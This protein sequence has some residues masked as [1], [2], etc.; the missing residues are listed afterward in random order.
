M[1][2]ARAR[3]ALSVPLA[4]F[5]AACGGA[6]EDALDPFDDI[7]AQESG[8]GVSCAGLELCPSD[9]DVWSSS[10]RIGATATSK[11]ELLQFFT[12]TATGVPERLRVR[13]R[14]LRAFSN[15]ATRVHAKILAITSTVS[16]I[17]VSTAPVVATAA[18]G[19]LELAT[20]DTE[21]D[22]T[23]GGTVT[24][25]LL[26]QG[27]EYALWIST[28]EVTGAEQLL[29]GVGALR[30]FDYV[31]TAQR[32]TLR[33]AT[34]GVF[35]ASRFRPAGP[36][37]VAFG[38]ALAID[39][40]TLGLDDCDANATC[41]DQPE[42][43]SCTCNTNYVGPGTACTAVNMCVLN[44]TLCGAG[45]CSFTGPGTWSCT[46]PLGTA[47]ANGTC[48]PRNVSLGGDGV[49][50]W[51]DGTHA[52]SC[53]G[54][55]NPPA[56]YLYSGNTGSG[57][58]RLDPQG[59]GTLV[60]AYCDMATSIG[61]TLAAKIQSGSGS[62]WL[63][64]ATRWTTAGQLLNA[65]DLTLNAGEAKYATF[66]A[67]A[68][69]QIRLVD[70]ASGRKVILPKA[71][72]S[73]QSLFATTAPPGIN[74]GAAGNGGV[75]ESPAETTV[76]PS[77]YDANAF[78][79]LSSANPL[80]ICNPASLGTNTDVGFNGAGAYKASGGTARGRTRL[81]VWHSG[82]NSWIWTQTA[83]CGYGIGVSTTGYGGTL[84]SGTTM[85]ALTTLWVRG[86]P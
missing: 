58:Y 57:I 27:T 39:E 54:Y 61:W 51:S 7:D 45:T 35:A 47:F 53:D 84:N 74:E 85:G 56:P 50:A 48:E 1:T 16:P 9:G 86:T 80:S 78:G 33:A 44:A 64:D 62:A 75:P 76:K 30:T 29:V 23:E 79:L 42:G 59:N 71:A 41:H 31:G 11:S 14:H 37:D 55:R 69:D 34:P 17:N 18:L 28:D 81:G 32:R 66:D 24:P 77:T 25:G 20:S 60:A 21:F 49:R 40:C 83:D 43:F 68:F 46:C 15:P 82:S 19:A 2:A 12:A 22:F 72:T 26:E 4:L 65:T 73:L 13:L 52:R 67:V 38:L 63:Y 6:G 8:V 3:S 70:Q 5:I 36:Y 10:Y